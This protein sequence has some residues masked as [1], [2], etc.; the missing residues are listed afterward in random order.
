MNGSEDHLDQVLLDVRKAYRLIYGYQR[1]ALDVAKY[2]GDQLGFDYAG[3]QAQF[4]RQSPD[5][6][7]GE[8]TESAWDWL[9]LVFYDCCFIK[10]TEKE[11]IRL[12]I[13][14]FSDTGYFTSTS[15]A[16]NKEDI[17]TFDRVENSGTK[18]GFLIYRTWVGDI[19]NSD[20]QVVKF[21]DDRDAIR[22]FLEKE[23]G[24]LPPELKVANIVGKCY[25]F[26]R[27]A[28]QSST[29][30]VIDEIVCFANQHGYPLKRINRSV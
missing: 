21:V 2:F 8:L 28:D 12:S 9:N 27:V 5:E 23:E 20:G 7:K 6:D 24:G 17:T 3:G 16:A 13:W 14:L 30:R 19:K 18:V 29:D 1:A 11:E 22:R 4:G 25:D 15:P 10:K 26:A